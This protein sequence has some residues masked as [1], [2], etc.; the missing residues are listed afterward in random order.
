MEVQSD[1]WVTIAMYWI[2]MNVM[3]YNLQYPYT[4][5]GSEMERIKMKIELMKLRIVSHLS[6]WLFMVS[7][8]VYQIALR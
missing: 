4:V 3:A 2:K 5:N 6:L 1:Y 7:Y 8:L